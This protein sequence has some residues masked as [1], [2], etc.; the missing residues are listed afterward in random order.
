MCFVKQGES[1]FY[2]KHSALKNTAEEILQKLWPAWEHHTHTHTHTHT[3]QQSLFWHSLRDAL[4]CK[5]LSDKSDT[6][7][8]HTLNCSI[9]CLES[10]SALWTLPLGPAW[11][12]NLGHT[13][14]TAYQIERELCVWMCTKAHAFQEERAN[15]QWNRVNWQTRDCRLLP[16]FNVLKRN[17][18]CLS[19][20]F[21]VM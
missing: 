17:V 12:A 1:T 9:W 15:A 11:K 16:L 3:D 5:W 4:W 7:C 14:D 10:S 21:K 18:F 20:N 2:S 19:E 13:S 8:Q 6:S